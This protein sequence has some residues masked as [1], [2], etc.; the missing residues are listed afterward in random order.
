MH[1][2]LRISWPEHHQFGVK[3]THPTHVKNSRFLLG[4]FLFLP[5]WV[6]SSFSIIIDLVII[7][8]L[9]IKGYLICKFYQQ[10]NSLEPQKHSF[11]LFNHPVLKNRLQEIAGVDVFSFNAKILIHNEIPNLK[12]FGN[13]PIPLEIEVA[14]QVTG[15][16]PFIDKN[17][18]LY[19][20]TA[21]SYVKLLIQ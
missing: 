21:C 20:I 6:R 2:G 10:S 17:N 1:R 13:C 19:P 12:L 18:R 11:Q 9:K 3:H 5:E 8:R 14:W 4:Y 15:K 16:L 7:S